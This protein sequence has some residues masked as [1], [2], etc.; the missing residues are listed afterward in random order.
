M[1]EDTNSAEQAKAELMETVRELDKAQNQ[2]AVTHG[3]TSGTPVIEGMESYE[4]WQ[5]HLDGIV[6]SLSPEGS[7]EQ[8]LAER[9][10]GLLWRLQRVTR[11]ETAETDRMIAIV[12]SD[13]DQVEAYVAA[14]PDQDRIQE[15]GPAENYRLKEQNLLPHFGEGTRCFD[16]RLSSSDL[17][18]RYSHPIPSSSSR[19]HSSA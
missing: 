19:T 2:N 13:T 14:N 7:L 4:A 18:A 5:R 9:V 17:S 8:E 15:V 16:V 11:Y 6:E 1:T 12:Q 3:I 10:A